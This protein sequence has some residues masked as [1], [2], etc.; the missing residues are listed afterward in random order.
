MKKYVIYGLIIVSLGVLILIVNITPKE[1]N[2]R[3]L[4]VDTQYTYLYQ[5]KQS[6]K[7][8]LYFNDGKIPVTEQE[9]Y[10]RF[11]VHDKDD[12]KSL[13]LE[14]INIDYMNSEQY[15]NETYY[16]YYYEFKIPNLANDFI[17]D[18]AILEIVFANNK[19]IELQLGNFELIYLDNYQELDWSSLDSKK[20]SSDSFQISNIMIEFFDNI[21][22]IDDI[23]IGSESVNF[24]MYEN[25]INV[26]IPKKDLVITN[27]PV[28]I[29][30]TNKIFVVKNHDYIIEYNLLEKVKKGI[31][32]YEFNIW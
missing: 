12:N 17:V 21:A 2:Y 27:L 13:V 29:N 4:T 26:I 5:K 7:L 9:G 18:D 14:L 15:L 1:K 19:R 23:K 8:F 24:I 3:I 20:E 28:I 6:L 32:N 25:A 11:K 31:N 16:K 10:E 30:T 22:K